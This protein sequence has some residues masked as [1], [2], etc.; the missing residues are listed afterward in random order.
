[1][2]A[3]GKIAFTTFDS[4]P[5]VLTTDQG[6]QEFAIENPL[7]IQQPLIQ[8]IVDELNGTGACPS[9]GV[10]GSRTSWVMDQMLKRID[11]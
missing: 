10:T 11:L 5:V 6:R 8:T 3:K 9:T 2:G 7:H 4:S 1:M